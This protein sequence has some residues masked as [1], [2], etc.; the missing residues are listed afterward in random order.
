MGVTLEKSVRCGRWTWTAPGRCGSTDRRV[1]RPSTSV[2]AS[3][4][5]LTPTV[6]LAES[7]DA[8]GY[9]TGVAAEIGTTADFANQYTYDNLGRM[10]QVEQSGQ[11][12]GNSVAAKRVDFAYDAASQ[13]D[14][15]TRYAN[16]AG[17]QLVAQ[18]AYTF[19]NASRLTGLSYTKGQTTLAGYTWTYNSAG[20]L[21]QFV[22]TVDGTANYTYDD[23]N[24]LAGATYTYQSTEAYTYDANGNRTNTGY[25]TGDDNRL[26]SDGVYTYLYDAEGNRTKRTRISDGAVTEYT[27]D[28]RNRLINVTERASTNGPAT[29][30]TEYTYDVFNRRVTKDVDTDGD[31]DFDRGE[32]YVYDGDNIVLQ[33]NLAST[34][35]DRYLF[36]PGVDQVLAD[37]NGSGVVSWL[38]ADQE[39]TIRDVARY[40][41]GTDTTTVVDHL[42]YDAFGEI[43]SQTNSSAEP[44]FAFT[45]R[46]WDPDSNLYYYRARWY[47][48]HTGRFLSQDPSGFRAGDTN[49]NRYV[50][51]RPTSLTDPTGLD[52]SGGGDGSGGNVLRDEWPLAS[53]AGG[54]W[55]QAAGPWGPEGWKQGSPPPDWAVGSGG[56]FPR[57]AS[58]AQ[59]LPWWMLD[60][61]FHWSDGWG[62][63]L[64]HPSAMD[65]DLQT[66]DKAAKV[67]IVV[68]AGGAVFLDGLAAYGVTQIGAVPISQVPTQILIE[69]GFLSGCGSAGICF[70]AGTPVLV[71]RGEDERTGSLADIDGPRELDG[72]LLASTAAF[73]LGVA[74]RNAERWKARRRRGG[75]WHAT[76]RV[77]DHDGQPDEQREDE[78]SSDDE[79]A[80]PITSP[81][82]TEPPNGGHLFRREG[83]AGDD[84]ARRGIVSPGQGSR[85][86]VRCSLEDDASPRGVP[87]ARVTRWRRLWLAACLLIAAAFAMRGVSRS[88]T[89][90]IPRTSAVA[91]STVPATRVIESIHVGERVLADNPDVPRTEKTTG[92]AV[93]PGTWR[94]FR[95]HAAETWPDGTLDEIEVETLQPPEWIKANKASVGATVPL[96]LDLREMGLPDRLRATVVADEPCPP[97]ASGPGNVVLTTA[98]RLGAHVLEVALA[99][100]HGRHETIRPTRFHKFYNERRGDWVSAE[101]LHEGDQLRGVT[102]PLTVLGVT[103]VPGVHRVYNMTVEGEHVYHVSTL[104]VLANN[105]GCLEEWRRQETS[106]EDQLLKYEMDAEEILRDSKGSGV[107]Y[108]I[109]GT[110]Q[111]IRNTAQALA[112]VKAQIKQ[113]LEGGGG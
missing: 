57:S 89:M 93:D 36:G 75:R 85:A 33:F 47:D 9:R 8:A 94:R 112:E 64:T 32:R 11:S 107:P 105:N 101:H 62:Y 54:W 111:A 14:T 39:G 27:W 2:E 72:N 63:Y 42:T 87:P 103:H 52:G 98:S 46:D 113:A 22:S 108:S 79:L 60:S 102:G 71:P 67:A 88:G 65:S 109:E 97:I 41:S 73:A 74:G 61:V 58:R 3:I 83:K 34:L 86:N 49:L 91:P 17:T 100:S 21:T 7:Y 40:D 95:L 53:T 70:A 24:Q 45:G 1:T 96:P 31:E 82:R 81:L 51:N 48:P 25:S 84:C 18:S 99:D 15:I 23:T 56:W 19:D 68:G 104:G 66:W 69:L 29:K 38:L 90:S 16:L 55:Y 110:Y 37:E 80:M 59:P 78:A 50:W 5:G 30:V 92:T 4:D 106:L 35:T 26:T 44:H 6:T 13:F 77:L 12:G 76:D 20:R 10:T 43:I 28:Y